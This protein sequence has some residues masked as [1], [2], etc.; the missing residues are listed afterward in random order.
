M[1]KYVQISGSDDDTITFRKF[2]PEIDGDDTETYV[3]FDAKYIC[4]K[5][6]PITYY[7]K[8]C[9]ICDECFPYGYEHCY[10]CEVCRPERHESC[11]PE[12]PW[13]YHC[14]RDK[15][16]NDV[17]ELVEHESVVRYKIESVHSEN[18]FSMIPNFGYGKNVVMYA[19]LYVPDIAHNVLHELS[20]KSEIFRLEIFERKD[21][22]GKTALYLAIANRSKCLE[23]MLQMLQQL[24]KQRMCKIWK[25]MPSN[26]NRY[27]HADMFELAKEFYPESLEM[28]QQFY[29][30][31]IV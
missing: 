26:V 19:L 17:N 13:D 5:C 30:K 6:R 15:R 29:D 18:M 7:Y 8:H 28:L 21:Y 1:Y 16:Y 31:Y 11:I 4:E 23:Q 14:P 10:R 2:S 9:D 24:P 3:I 20:F 27:K 22:N 25:F 12:H